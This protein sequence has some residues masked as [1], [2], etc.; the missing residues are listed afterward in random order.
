MSTFWGVFVCKGM[1]RPD[2]AVPFLNAMCN[3][4]LRMPVLDRKKDMNKILVE[5]TSFLT[6]SVVLGLT[7]KSTRQ[8]E[9][10]VRITSF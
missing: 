10:T 5:M 7:D 1:P 8:L 4:T 6:R 9:R 2:T 3:A